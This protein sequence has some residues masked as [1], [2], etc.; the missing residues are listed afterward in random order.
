[1]QVIEELIATEQRY[2]DNLEILINVCF[3]H[4][5]LSLVGIS[6]FLT[7]LNIIQVFYVP[8]RDELLVPEEDLKTIFCNI[9]DIQR[10]NTLFLRRLKERLDTTS[11]IPVQP[12]NA[13]SRCGRSSI[14]LGDIFNEVAS[15]HM[16]FVCCLYLLLRQKLTLCFCF[17]SVPLPENLCQVLPKQPCSHCS[18]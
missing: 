11:C 5:I 4:F 3:Y 13:Q 18:T 10:L 9:E 14:T 17:N 12:D 1:M 2:N 7:L 15:Y 16:A 8:L 6:F